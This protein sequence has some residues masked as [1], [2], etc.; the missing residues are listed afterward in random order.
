MPLTIDRETRLEET[1]HAIVK[2]A[3]AYRREAE[4][5]NQPFFVENFRR[6]RD[7][8]NEANG[9]STTSWTKE[10]DP[11]TVGDEE[12]RREL[13]LALAKD[14]TMTVHIEAIADTVVRQADAI[15]A[16]MKR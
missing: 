1:L 5:L 12:F 11:E 2:Q 16:R 9:A 3:D 15:I 7:M 14:W 8:A 6:L 4:R 10:F 13:V